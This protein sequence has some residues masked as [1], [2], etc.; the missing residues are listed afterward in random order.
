MQSPTHRQL[1][2]CARKRGTSWATIN[3]SSA[4]K[5]LDEYQKKMGKDSLRLVQDVD[6]SWN[7]QYLMLSRLL[8]LKE[9]V[10]VELA[11]SNCSIDGLCSAEWKEALEYLDA[12]KPLYDATVIT[13][14]D[15]YPSLSTQI[16]IIFGMLS[17]LSNFSGTT[18]FHKELARSLNTRF[19]LYTEDKEACL[20]MFLDPR[21]KSTVF[22]NNKQ[23][24]VWLKD[25]VFQDVALCPAV[26]VVQPAAKV[27]E[28]QQ[29]VQPSSDV[30]SAFDNL[31]NSQV[32]STPLSTSE[33]ETK[34]YSEEALLKKDSDPCDWWQTVG[35][36]RY[37]KYIRPYQP[38]QFQA[39]VPF[40]W[41]GRLSLFGGS[42][43]CL[44][45]LAKHHVGC[46]NKTVRRCLR[47]SRGGAVC[48]CPSLSRSLSVSG[49]LL[50]PPPA[51]ARLWPSC[52]PSFKPSS[53]PVCCSLLHTCS[54]TRRSAASLGGSTRKLSESLLAWGGSANGCLQ[55]WVCHGRHR[56][57]SAVLDEIM[58]DL[59]GSGDEH[60]TAPPPS[61]DRLAPLN[62]S[63]A[64]GDSEPD[65]SYGTPVDE[66]PPSTSAEHTSLV[67]AILEAA[68]GSQLLARSEDLPI[69]GE[70]E[71]HDKLAERRN[72]CVVECSLVDCNGVSGEC[73]L[74]GQ[75]PPAG[76]V[77]EETALQSARSLTHINGF[78]ADDGTVIF[79]PNQ[80]LAT[81]LPGGV[82]GS[83]ENGL[84]SQGPSDED[85]AQSSISGKPVGTVPPFRTVAATDSKPT[86]GTGGAG[87]GGHERAVAELA[88]LSGKLVRIHSLM[89]AR[90]QERLRT[91]HEQIE[92]LKQNLDTVCC[93]K[94]QCGLEVGELRR[95][96]DQ[97]CEHAQRLEQQMASL[98]DS[99][100]REVELLFQQMG[101][102][103]EK[104]RCLSAVNQ[105]Q[106][107]QLQEE[108]S[109]RGFSSEA[110][111]ICAKLQLRQELEQLREEL[112]LKDEQLRALA[113]KFGRFRKAYED[114]Y[115]RATDDIDKLD[116]ML[117]R[118]IE[119][120]EAE[121]ETVSSCPALRQ[122]L[123]N[124]RGGGAGDATASTPSGDS[125]TNRKMPTAL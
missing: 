124:L 50:K 106:G 55:R 66:L 73:G 69:N 26:E 11:T 36:F 101:D 84:G 98:Q 95:Q 32:A 114:N 48:G 107:R 40:Q 2:V 47:Y 5:R 13:S 12:L 79:R 125:A 33:W 7:S 42:A 28:P 49:P 121:P 116:T 70:S 110:D 74:R 22:R 87:V 8:D 71:V 67:H 120:L 64:N 94:A 104:N 112:L 30:W 31:A 119:T 88:S 23:K 21:F 93:Q 3:S 57:P 80:C 89:Q 56:G 37:P 76:S 53:R 45:M 78:H 44:I 25:L 18:G 1:T 91:D 61:K 38:L 20:A 58:D 113:A 39:S 15:K 92:E 43:S 105:E 75:L 108:L 90:V 65:S 60:P 83:S 85:A 103:K 72:L 4:H 117:E 10:S 115:Q 111:A 51:V 86:A 82:T 100:A 62:V 81:S 109:K 63:F 54:S 35:T 52:Q 102:L 24:L 122:L 29:C 16:P 68:A 6:T 41:Q 27:Q 99:H 34:A 77:V 123:H 96:R 97:A 59:E 9:A 46:V 118:V 17:C 14:A 19:P